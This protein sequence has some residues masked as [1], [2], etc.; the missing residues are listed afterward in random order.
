LNDDAI[1]SNL[2]KAFKYLNED[3]ATGLTS[4]RIAVES[5]VKTIVE[6]KAG[7]LKN[8]KLDDM[9]KGLSILNLVPRMIVVELNHI[10]IAANY[11]VHAGG[12]NEPAGDIT[13]FVASLKKVAVWYFTEYKK[14]RYPE[15]LQNI[16]TPSWLPRKATLK[17]IND[18]GWKPEEIVKSLIEL[19]YDTMNGIDELH[20]GT[21]DQWVPIYRSYPDLWILLTDAPKSIA[22]YWH[23]IAL[24]ESEFDKAIAGKLHD[25]MIK[26]ENI[27]FPSFPGNYDIYFSCISLLKK[28]RDIK[29][30]KLLF[31]SFLEKLDEL[32]SCGVFIR[33]ICANA[34]T[35]E[36][37][38]LCRTIK[39]E[40]VCEHEDQ[41]KV[42]LLDMN[43]LPKLEILKHHPGLL[44]K[45]KKWHEN[46]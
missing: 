2:Q 27:V 3:P 8:T 40:Y 12:D 30:F 6:S 32:A 20:V 16:T 22:G 14:E 34:F 41:G 43:N 39:M 7:H 19:D 13:S 31:E 35:E 26:L 38:A 33:R 36:G 45:Y 21:F 29:G 9:I 44:E 17:D 5:I 10:R 1:A 46:I 25:N 4:A 24:S 15:E 18:W 23:Y 28:Y 11:M 42:F 37:I